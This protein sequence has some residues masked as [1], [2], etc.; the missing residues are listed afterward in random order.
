[1]VEEA[2]DLSRF[3]AGGE[4][5]AP[6]VLKPNQRPELLEELRLRKSED[7]V[8]L[9]GPYKE[10]GFL[11]RELIPHHSVQGVLDGEDFLITFCGACNAGVHMIPVIDGVT[12]HFRVIGAYNGQ[13]V[14]QDDETRSIWNHVTG[15]CMHGPLEGRR[16]VVK[17]LRM[18]TAA[19]EMIENPNLP[20]FVSGQTLASLIQVFAVRKLLGYFQNWLPR[21]FLRTMTEV[22]GRLPK[23]TMGLV[24]QV[25]T[26]IRFYAFSDIFDGMSDI[27]G[28]ETLTFSTDPV[29]QVVDHNGGR[30]FQML[31]RWYAFVLTYP[32]GSLYKPPGGKT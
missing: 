28:S 15:V 19:K 11:L 7:L 3:G 29:P 5:Y 20:V 1:M 27:L 13:A 18:S 31:M 14:F 25:D 32:E 24:V 12:H 6:W 22:D 2:F 16:L 21:R 17:A 26:E 9:I 23:L 30:P 8:I 10:Y 4:L